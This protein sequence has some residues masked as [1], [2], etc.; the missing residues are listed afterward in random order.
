MTLLLP[1]FRSMGEVIAKRE[2]IE[3]AISSGEIDQSGK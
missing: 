1:H 2:D 3:L